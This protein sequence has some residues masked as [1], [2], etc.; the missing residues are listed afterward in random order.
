MSTAASGVPTGAG[1][2]ALTAERVAPAPDGHPPSA[3]QLEA[4]LRVATTVPDHGGLRPWRFV[5]V[6][7]AAAQERFGAALV[8]GLLEQRGDDVPGAAVAKMRAKATAAPCAVVLVAAPDPATNVAE[9]EQVA[10][11]ACTGYALVLAATSIGLG[12]VW[13]S[14]SVL[15]TR[16][17]REAFGLAAHERLLG[18]VNVGEP[19]A[20]RRRPPVPVPLDAHVSALLPGVTSSPD[21]GR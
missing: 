10:S 9:W 17:V 4:I 1:Y 13:K 19:G 20:P 11:A 21:G 16:A 15:E 3:E 7:G 12:A 8:S 14:A 6:S 18:W 2:A 5:V